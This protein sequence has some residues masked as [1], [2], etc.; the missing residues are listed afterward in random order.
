[1][2]MGSKELESHISSGCSFNKREE[3]CIAKPKFNVS[4]EK[5]IERVWGDA[6]TQGW[7]FNDFAVQLIE[8]LA[9]LRHRDQLKSRSAPSKRH[10]SPG[11]HPELSG[12]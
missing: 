2:R 4:I 6:R 7:S 10:Q 3:D 5:K 9:I 1:M 12:D 8:V 11:R